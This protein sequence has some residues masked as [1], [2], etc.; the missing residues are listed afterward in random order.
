MA[1][2]TLGGVRPGTGQMAFVVVPLSFTA[3]KARR[4]KHANSTRST[5]LSLR[6]RFHFVFGPKARQFFDVWGSDQRQETGRF[7]WME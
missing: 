1:L 5:A 6:I 7:L 2:E 4:A 3:R